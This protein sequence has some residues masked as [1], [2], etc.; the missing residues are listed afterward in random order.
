MRPRYFSLSRRRINIKHGC[1][2]CGARRGVARPYSCYRSRRDAARY[3]ARDTDRTR[4]LEVLNRRVNET[5]DGRG[6]HCPFNDNFLLRGF[7]KL[8][9][10]IMGWVGFI[11]ILLV[12]SGGH[13][14]HYGARAI[15]SG[16]KMR[17]GGV[18]SDRCILNTLP[19]DGR[20]L[21]FSHWVCNYL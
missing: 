5:S 7:S 13:L 16:D 6:R 3:C 17:S 12:A 4:Y 15:I 11:N 18:C 20:C 8:T 21:L 2:V 1:R 9:R 19:A 14:A 10:R